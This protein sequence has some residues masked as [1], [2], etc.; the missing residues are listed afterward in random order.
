MK[1]SGK[2]AYTVSHSSALWNKCKT[3]P[4]LYLKVREFTQWGLYEYQ[5]LWI[6]IQNLYLKPEAVYG[7]TWLIFLD[8]SNIPF[9]YN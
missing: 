8:T 5:A 2:Q 3:L 6:K 1:A 7:S 9:Q 4:R